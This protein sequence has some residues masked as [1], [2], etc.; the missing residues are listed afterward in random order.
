M[1]ANERLQQT[2]NGF[3]FSTIS[4]LPFA[5]YLEADMPRP[6]GSKNK[7]NKKIKR[8]CKICGNLFYVYPCRINHRLCS[9]KCRWIY[10]R[11]KSLSLKTRQAISGT[12]TGRTLSKIVCK[13]ISKAKL[14]NKNPKYTNG[15]SSY[16]Q[17][18]LRNLPH[19]CNKCG[20]DKNVRIL[21]VHHK[22][23]NR[24]NNKLD[25]L[26]ILCLN[27]HAI[28]HKRWNNLRKKDNCEAIV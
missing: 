2:S 6:K 27:C 28:V 7:I 20:F 12:Q 18:A 26:K 23:E 15:N 25:N 24:L 19:R 16:R 14:G 1:I 8:I 5:S 11:G 9:D 22:D 13:N 3:G 17:L 10:G 21:L 4:S